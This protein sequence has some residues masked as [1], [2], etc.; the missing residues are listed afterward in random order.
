MCNGQN[1]SIFL[2][3]THG[4]LICLGCR[5]SFSD[6]LDL[7]NHLQSEHRLTLFMKNNSYENHHPSSH[8]NSSSSGTPLLQRQLHEPLTSM[9]SRYNNWNPR[10]WISNRAPFDGSVPSASAAI[11]GLPHWGGGILPEHAAA[12]RLRLLAVAASDGGEPSNGGDV[13]QTVNGNGKSASPTEKVRQCP[14][15]LKTFRLVLR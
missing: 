9:E 10:N 12:E 14:H 13:K 15:C 1:H 5:H 7:L 4:P 3:D 2:G 8:S 11:A 6:A